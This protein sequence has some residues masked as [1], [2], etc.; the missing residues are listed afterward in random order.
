MKLVHLSLAFI[1]AL[2]LALG[3][4]A[5]MLFGIEDQQKQ[6]EQVMSNRKD[7][8]ALTSRIE[9]D[10]HQLSQFVRAYTSTGNTNYLLYYY[11][12]IA[13]RK[14]T[15]PE[16]E[17]YDSQYWYE[18]TTG[19]REHLFERPPSKSKS[20]F[21]QLANL[22]FSPQETEYLGK[23]L[24]I[25]EQMARTEQIAF[26]ATQGLYD[27][28]TQTFVDEGEPQI[29]FAIGLV[30]N[31]DYLRLNSELLYQVKN[32]TK[33]TDQRTKVQVQTAQAQVVTATRYA[34]LTVIISATLLFGMGYVVFK[35]ILSPLAKL[36]EASNKLQY[37]QYDT[38]ASIGKAVKEIDQIA[39]NFNE[40]AANIEADITH[41]TL[42]EHELMRE[43]SKAEEAR[44]QLQDSINSAALIQQT[45]TPKDEALNAFFTEQM[46][47][48]QPKDVVGG[49]IYL[50]TTLRH[51]EESLL[52]VIDCT[53]HG[54]PGAF[55]TMLIK[56]IHQQLVTNLKHRQ[57]EVSPAK[58]LAEF[59][60]TLKRLLKQEEEQQKTLRAQKSNY[61][62]VG[63]D[64][65]IVYCDKQ[66][67]L[68]RFA[69][70]HTSLY[71][72]NGSDLN[73]VKGDRQS[74]GYRQ[75]RVDFEFN[76]YDLI[77][78]PYSVFY[79]TTD[80]FIDQNGGSKGLPFGKK[81]FEKIM[82]DYGDQALVRQRTIF[83]KEHQ[84]YQQG[85]NQ[86]DDITLLAFR[87]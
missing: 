53:G 3:V 50:F 66:R 74:I 37:N 41:R 68:V 60:V 57:G 7:S 59:N 20:L 73:I 32:L 44:Q 13:I 17:D 14:G 64:G 4:N 82:L 63:F 38:R 35:R 62:D 19:V 87:L 78:T 58:L 65:A 43:K 76:E 34:I 11:D 18:V 69:G 46:H 25:S 85:E 81:R 70:A 30:N 6:V 80:G 31:P 52:M 21:Q 54:V 77:A 79:L 45:L 48:W 75:S 39:R 2:L 16:P 8:V 26:A 55:L 12:L 23:I 36:L 1:T 33:E 72:L 51:E 5:W 61:H 22:S 28:K 10:T 56:A 9:N 42:I 29:S 49:D 84:A 15:K 71:Y 40:M 27:P 67:N 83:L 24:D 47:I 86:T